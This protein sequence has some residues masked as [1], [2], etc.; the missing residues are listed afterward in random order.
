MSGAGGGAGYDSL[1]RKE[2]EGIIPH[3][4]PFLFISEVRE[5]DEGKSGV[6]VF[7]PED[8]PWITEGHFPGNPIVP[9]F[10]TAEA[11]AQTGAVILLATGDYEGMGVRLLGADRL[12]WRAPIIPEEATVYLH[13]TIKATRKVGDT[14][15]GTAIGE[16]TINRDRNKPVFSGE[17][18]FALVKED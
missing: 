16:A 14:V 4:K 18:S 1:N 2:I 6:G 11:M 9:G 10:I 8:T 7:D 3:R 13:V 12:K 15:F 17:V 5:I